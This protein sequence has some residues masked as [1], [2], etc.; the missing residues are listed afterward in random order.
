MP[1]R[2][3]DGELVLSAATYCSPLGLVVGSLGVVYP[4]CTA[5]YNSGNVKSGSS[6]GQQLSNNSLYF[7]LFVCRIAFDPTHPGRVKAVK[8]V[9]GR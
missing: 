1:T 2:I 7:P 5:S 8:S 3:S 6:S 4:T 9:L